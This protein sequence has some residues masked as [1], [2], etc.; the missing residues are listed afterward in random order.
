MLA[1]IAWYPAARYKAQDL[2]DEEPDYIV[3]A[4]M[5]S[6]DCDPTEEGWFLFALQTS[7]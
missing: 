1:G 2:K 4:L 6:A 3:L 5:T 7:Y